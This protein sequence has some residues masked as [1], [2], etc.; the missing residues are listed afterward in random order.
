MV[1]FTSK[2]SAPLKGTARVPSDKSISHRALLLSS[3]AEGESTLHHL[4]MGEDN[5]ATMAAMQA[6][7]VKIE[8][9]DDNTH[10][11]KG[12]GLFGL[13][14]PQDP[15]NLGNSGT[16][17]R[18]LAGLLVGQPFE[19]R[20]VG[21][22]SLMQRPMKRIVE[23]LRK[24]GARI[25]MSLNGTPPLHIL[26]THN[27]HGIQYKMPIA[28]AQVKSCLLLAGLYA[29]GKTEII[30]PAPTRDHLERMLQAMGYVI[31]HNENS[32]SLKSGGHL[33]GCEMHIPADI[34][35]A[36]FFIVAASIIPTSEIVLTQ[37]GVN[38][39]RIGVITILKK[40]GA[41]IRL[42]NPIER[43]GE[44]VADI[45]VRFAQLKGIDIPMN[46]VP[47]AIDELPVI[48]IA[49]ACAKGKTLLKGAKELRVKESDR[50]AA[51]AEGLQRLG[52]TVEVFEDGMCVEGG[53]LQGGTVDSFADHRIAMAFV[54]AGA[55][56][57]AP[58]TI[59]N[60]EN[61]ETSFPQFKETATSLG[62][63]I[64]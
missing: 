33:T 40:M 59:H 49:A 43:S 22:A 38:F 24:M 11:V 39:T 60:C 63:E 41:D 57:Q 50:I 54:I 36:A 9:L 45:N 34:S 21:D 56:A 52:I 28:S 26:P 64:V 47:L 42:S 7:G 35:S 27:L 46:Q 29:T 23:P 32:I 2:P 14:P 12:V 6:M 31:H 61:I 10:L 3:I 8:A 30:E 4:L 18:L 20:M 62:L 58:V 15:L 51:M 13:T 19:S 5:K 17:M 48:L 55:A 53:T 25:A 16:G 1:E 37:V 44:P